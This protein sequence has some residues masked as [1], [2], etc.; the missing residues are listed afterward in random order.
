M[1]FV[2]ICEEKENTTNLQIVEQ[3]QWKMFFSEKLSGTYSKC[4]FSTR[5]GIQN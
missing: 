4:L 2:R 1:R 5:L 3:N